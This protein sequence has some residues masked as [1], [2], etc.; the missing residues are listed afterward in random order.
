MIISFCANNHSV[1]YFHTAGLPLPTTSPTTG[2]DAAD[3]LSKLYSVCSV[4][5]IST[6]YAYISSPQSGTSPITY[7]EAADSSFIFFIFYFFIYENFA[8]YFKS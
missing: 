1:V 7:S 3:S 4:Q 2:S 8:L 5:C 6:P